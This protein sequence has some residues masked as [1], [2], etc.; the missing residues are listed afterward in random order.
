MEHAPFSLLSLGTLPD[1]YPFFAEWRE[2][3]A[4]IAGAEGFAVTRYHDVWWLM[5]DQRISHEF[6]RAMLEYALGDGAMADF[7]A[8][9][10]LNREGSATIIRYWSGC[11]TAGAAFLSMSCS[12]SSRS[13]TRSRP[14]IGARMEAWGL[15]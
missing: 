14:P 5:R 3:G 9:S 13:S 11:R 4:V 2:R 12:E 15:A 6:P 10:L 7:Q 1:P 8:N